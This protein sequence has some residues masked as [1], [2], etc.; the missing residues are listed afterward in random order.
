MDVL[1]ADGGTK[2]TIELPNSVFGKTGT[3]SL[4]WETVR[5]YLANQRQGT[6]KVKTRAE[7]SGT[8]K[9]PYRQKHTGRARHG[10]RRS[11]L[12][13]GGGVVFGPHPRDYGISVPK[14]KRRQAL[15][16][17]LSVRHAEGSV[18]VVEDFELAA[19]KTK[20][21][22]G[23]LSSLD[24]S[25]SVLLLVAEATETMTRASRNIP[26]LTVMPSQH[27]H[28]YAVLNC[29]NVLFTESGLKKFLE[30]TGAA[31]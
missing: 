14:K 19:P 13:V 1:A 4:L 26:W 31:G 29:G 7:V 11:P 6:S 27:V 25:G 2:G 17:A 28:T 20:E 3:D 24:L 8:G 5:A 21:L 15:R 23:V 30:M 22:A 18:K 10:S 12:H 16:I 9:K